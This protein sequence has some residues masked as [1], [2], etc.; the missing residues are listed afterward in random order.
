MSHKARVTVFGRLT[1]K[2]IFVYKGIIKKKKK[3]TH[4]G[5]GKTEA[6]NIP[7]KTLSPHH[8]ETPGFR[9]HPAHK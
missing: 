9:T 8:G 1:L 3:H 4:L 5:P 6:Q 7:E 2:R